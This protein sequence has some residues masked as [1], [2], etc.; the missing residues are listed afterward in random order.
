MIERW[1]DK[2]KYKSQASN[3]KHQINPHEQNSKPQTKPSR[4]SLIGI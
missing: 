1:G 3:S 2:E 4:S